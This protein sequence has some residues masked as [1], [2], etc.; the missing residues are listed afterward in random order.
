MSLTMLHQTN[1]KIGTKHTVVLTSPNAEIM[2]HE[3]VAGNKESWAWGV[4]NAETLLVKLPRL[5][6]KRFFGYKEKGD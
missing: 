3:D 2:S 6:C 1:R 4:K 5:P